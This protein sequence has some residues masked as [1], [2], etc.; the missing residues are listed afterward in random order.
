MAKYFTFLLLTAYMF[1]FSSCKNKREQTEEEN[2]NNKT[3]VVKLQP[4]DISDVPL[5]NREIELNLLDG[6]F[7]VYKPTKTEVYILDKTN[8]EK[9]FQPNVE[10]DNRPRVI[11]FEREG[12]GAIV[13]PETNYNTDI[14]L[15]SAYVRNNTMYITYSIDESIEELDKP[16]QPLLIFTFDK[17]LDV[18]S[19]SFKNEGVEI[20]LPN[21]EE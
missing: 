4:D 17:K 6:Y 12:A 8:F 11:D 14:V 13:L 16:I 15:D 7:S 20:I 2:E 1:S 3:E 21:T 9:V 18:R 5:I 19:I 10:V